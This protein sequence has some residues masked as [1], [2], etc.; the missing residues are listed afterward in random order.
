MSLD[1]SHS[2]LLSAYAGSEVWSLVALP[3]GLVASGLKSGEIKLWNV[4]DKC[5]EIKSW[6]AHISYV[7]SMILT[8]DGSLVSGS[9]DKTISVS[10]MDTGKCERK[11][12]C[13]D[14]TNLLLLLDNGDI[15]S[16]GGG[17]TAKL[18]HNAVVVVFVC[19][20]LL[21]YPLCCVSGRVF[22]RVGCTGPSPSTILTQPAHDFITCSQFHHTGGSTGESIKIWNV[23]APAGQELERELSGPCTLDGITALLDLTDNYIA[24]G[25]HDHTIRVWSAVSGECVRVLSG[26]TD[27]VTCFA[28]LTSDMDSIVSGSKDNALRIWNIGSGECCAVL[29]GHTD[30]VYCV[31]ALPDYRIASGSADNTVR[32]WNQSTGRCQHVLTGHDD[33]VL[34][35]AV[36]PDGRF[37]SGSVDKTIRLWGQ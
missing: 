24:S 9:F 35:L 10:S 32:I 25:A 6:C 18:H 28:V 7:P 34:S 26:H 27:R 20:T 23:N 16:S 3:N 14:A 29:T 33:W 15:V 2:D 17:E 30:A 8:P 22:I 11:I 36:L 21:V 1:Y 13:S 4:N 12:Q 37:V 19:D 5:F 31:V